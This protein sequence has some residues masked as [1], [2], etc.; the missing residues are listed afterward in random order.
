LL[1]LSLENEDK[2]KYVKTIPEA[3]DTL[4]TPAAISFW[5]SDDGYSYF[6]QRGGL[7]LCTDSFNIEEVLNLKQVLEIKFKL[8]CTIQTKYNKNKNKYF[9]IYVSKSSMPLLRELVK[10]FMH[11]SMLYKIK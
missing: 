10:D 2:L 5:I 1:Y 8:K 3:I 11:V 6:N 9:R 7:T 4:L